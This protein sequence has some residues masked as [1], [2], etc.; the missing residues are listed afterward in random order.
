MGPTPKI[1]R[2]H[3]E[4]YR[5]TLGDGALQMIAARPWALMRHKAES[6]IDELLSMYR[7]GV[8]LE[9]VEQDRLIVDSLEQARTRFNILRPVYSYRPEDLQ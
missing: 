5:G 8:Q 1:S 4:A 6:Y 9:I 2:G 3:N 7:F